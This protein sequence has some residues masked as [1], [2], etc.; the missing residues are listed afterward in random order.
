MHMASPLGMLERQVSKFG[1]P[2][3]KPEVRIG[4]QIV[5]LERDS[6]KYSMEVRYW[7]G[8]GGN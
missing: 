7:I 5:Y 1:F 4:V 3:G 6:S 2:K 8:R